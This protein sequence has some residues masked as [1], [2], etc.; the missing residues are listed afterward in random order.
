MWFIMEHE[1]DPLSVDGVMIYSNMKFVPQVAQKDWQE[2]DVL[3][4]SALTQNA[5]PDRKTRWNF[6]EMSC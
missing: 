3:L 6:V 4:L 2:F 5:C 1:A